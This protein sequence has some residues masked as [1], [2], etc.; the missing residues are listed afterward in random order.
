MIIKY[1]ESFEMEERMYFY[2][3]G[4]GYFYNILKI[5]SKNFIFSVIKTIRSFIQE[6]I[7]M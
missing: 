5:L 7:R 3:K 2:I 6:T 4:L 1:S